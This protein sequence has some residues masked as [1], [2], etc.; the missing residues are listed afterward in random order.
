MAAM[1]YGE[2]S[3]LPTKNHVKRQAGTEILCFF[4]LIVTFDTTVFFRNYIY[5]LQL[6]RVAAQK[7]GPIVFVPQLT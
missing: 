7:E 2:K 5:T 4:S 6:L 3:H 1:T